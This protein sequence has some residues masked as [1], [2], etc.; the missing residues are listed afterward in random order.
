MHFL[1]NTYRG[2]DGESEGSEHFRDWDFALPLPKTAFRFGDE[3]EAIAEKK[4][5]EKRETSNCQ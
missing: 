5:E 1:R 2:A 4:M 3:M